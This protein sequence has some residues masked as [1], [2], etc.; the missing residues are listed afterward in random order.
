VFG[1]GRTQQVDAVATPV[2]ATS[3][4]ESLAKGVPPAEAACFVAMKAGK[5]VGSVGLDQVQ[6]LA[7]AA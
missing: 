2:E 6:L 1:A 3:T 5:L 7:A 4:M